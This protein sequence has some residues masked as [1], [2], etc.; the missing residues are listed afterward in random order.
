MGAISLQCVFKLVHK[1]KLSEYTYIIL[2]GIFAAALITVL[3]DWHNT[4]LDLMNGQ[5]GVFAATPDSV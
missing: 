5:I 4:I 3:F 1:T 2:W